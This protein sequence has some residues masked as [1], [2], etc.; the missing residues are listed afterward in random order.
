M[1]D[2]DIIGVGGFRREEVW[3]VERINAVSLTW[4]IKRFIDD[5]PSILEGFEGG[6][7]VGRY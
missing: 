5:N 1:K 2:L 6:Y 4:N 7:P 3:L